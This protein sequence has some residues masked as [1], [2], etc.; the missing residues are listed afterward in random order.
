[1]AENIWF[2]HFISVGLEKLLNFTL[3]QPW[4]FLVRLL[5]ARPPLLVLKLVLFYT[6]QCCQRGQFCWA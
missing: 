4:G 5:V 6:I 2:Y 1:M 3:H